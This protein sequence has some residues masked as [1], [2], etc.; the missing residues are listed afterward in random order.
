MPPTQ[1]SGSLQLSA[2]KPGGD[3][4]FEPVRVVLKMV[5]ARDGAGNRQQSIGTKARVVHL[6]FTATSS[7]FAARLDDRFRFRALILVMR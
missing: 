1:V 5:A 6:S 4:G 2:A 7:L 3:R